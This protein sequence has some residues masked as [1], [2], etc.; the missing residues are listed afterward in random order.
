MPIL[1]PIDQRELHRLI[2]PAVSRLPLTPRLRDILLAI[3]TGQQSREIAASL[4]ISKYTVETEIKELC[5]RLGVSGHRAARSIVLAI[6][7]DVAKR[8]EAAPPTLAA[9]AHRSQDTTRSDG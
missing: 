8:M 3:G 1:T 7:M 6:V 2:E 5:R 9:S 4:G